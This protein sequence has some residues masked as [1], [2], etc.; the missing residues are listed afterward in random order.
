MGFRACPLILVGLRGGVHKS[1]RTTFRQMSVVL[2]NLIVSGF[3]E[4]FDRAMLKT[5]C[6]TH[7]LNVASECVVHERVGRVYAKHAVGDDDPD[8]DIA[9]IFEPCLEFI[10]GAHAPDVG[11]VVVVHCLEGVSRSCCIVMAYLTLVLGWDA[12]EAVRHLRARRPQ[13]DVYP[14]Y[15]QTF[16]SWSASSAL[17]AEGAVHEQKLDQNSIEGRHKAVPSRGLQTTMSPQ[18]LVKRS[19]RDRIDCW[20]NTRASVSALAPGSPLLPSPSTK[21]RLDAVPAADVSRFQSTEVTV[22]DADSID[23]GLAY[24]ARGYNPAVLNLADDVMPGGCVDI[25]SGAQEESLFRRTTLCGTLVP[26]L[27]PIGPEEGIYS[28]AVAVLKASESVGWTPLEPPPTLAFLTVPGIKY[29]LVDYK[30]A[31]MERSLGED[32]RGGGDLPRL[33]AADEMRLERKVR[34]M[35]RIAAEHGH[36][37]VVLGASGCGAWKCP[38]DHVAE[39]FARVVAEHR[40]AFRV[41]A[42]AVLKDVDDHADAKRAMGIPDNHGVFLARLS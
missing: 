9:S 41:V 18:Q 35:L 24:L 14:A 6:V 12:D 15:M 31:G 20:L 32:A 23:C 4:S 25:G 10:R 5:N 11:G 16:L 33:R 26:E 22:E 28:P 13:M 42:F 38:P 1:M 36:D 27:Y 37:A 17:R 7:I 40:G 34:L 29:P 21:H 8:A 2:P 39:V 19:F 3:E 30:K